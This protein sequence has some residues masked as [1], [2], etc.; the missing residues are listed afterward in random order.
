MST[1]DSELQS[2]V[3]KSVTKGFKAYDEN[4]LTNLNLS[5]GS[6]EVVSVISKNDSGKSTLLKIIAGQLEPTQGNV[7]LHGHDPWS[8]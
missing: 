2:V 6:G 4:L 8:D 5:V 3:L 1:H 7:I